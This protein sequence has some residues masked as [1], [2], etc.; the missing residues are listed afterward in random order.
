MKNLKSKFI[1]EIQNDVQQ[2]LDS[3][4]MLEQRLKDIPNEIAALNGHVANL[5]GL[6]KSVEADTH[7]T[8]GNFT[9]GEGDDDDYEEYF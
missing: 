9:Y 6:Q 2:T 7:F 8:M 3:I 1:K 4:K 5:Y